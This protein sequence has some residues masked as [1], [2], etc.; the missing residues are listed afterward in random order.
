M[1]IKNHKY[2]KSLFFNTLRCNNLPT[3]AKTKTKTKTK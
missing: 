3:K 1:V 2:I